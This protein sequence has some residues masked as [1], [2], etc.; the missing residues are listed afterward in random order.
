LEGDGYPK[1]E[2][3]FIVIYLGLFYLYF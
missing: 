2:G 1:T 3:Y